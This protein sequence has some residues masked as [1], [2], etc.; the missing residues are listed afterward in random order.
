MPCSRRIGLPWRKRASGV[1]SRRSIPKADQS[2]WASSISL[3]DFEIHTARRRPCSQLSSR[4]PATWRPL[5]APVPSPSI[6]PRRNRTAFSA[7]S[8]AAETTSKV[9]STSHDPARWPLWA[10]PA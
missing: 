2:R 5:P 7:P 6:Q 1:I 9:S 8:G 10:S 3:S 4:M